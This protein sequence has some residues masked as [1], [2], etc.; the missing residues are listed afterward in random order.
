MSAGLLG[1]LGARL[2]VE[3]FGHGVREDVSVFAGRSGHQICSEIFPVRPGKDV[4][5]F[6]RRFWARFCVEIFADA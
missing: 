6:T 5:L 1:V 3:L 4:S 2:G